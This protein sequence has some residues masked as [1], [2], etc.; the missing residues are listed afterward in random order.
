MTT[1]TLT[2]RDLFGA[3]L[4]GTP[5]LEG[6]ARLDYLDLVELA[7]RHHIAAR[8]ATGDETNSYRAA[9]AMLDEYIE[10]L[11][12]AEELA[13]LEDDHRDD[14]FF[15]LLGEART[16]RAAGDFDGL[17]FVAERARALGHREEAAALETEAK[18][19]AAAQRASWR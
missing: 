15:D 19:H 16:C 11:V 4:V 3:P 12:A 10:E 8:Y 6:R 9:A 1:T 13:C 14:Q 7:Q 5:L 2:V 17:R 18:D